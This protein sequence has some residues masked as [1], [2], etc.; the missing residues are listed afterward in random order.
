MDE[1]IGIREFFAVTKT[2]LYRISVNWKDEKGEPEIEKIALKGESS[3][4]IGG[5]ITGGNLVGITKRGIVSYNNSSKNRYRPE[6][7]NILHHG[8]TTSP[9]TALFIKVGEAKIC[10][11]ESKNFQNC[12]P[13][14]RKQ[15]EEVL[16]AIG[17]N[18][19]VFILSVFDAISFE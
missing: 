17:D 18:H 1:K 2:S 16:A 19:P 13:R 3:V 7:V 8:G 10:F 4:P 6:Q 14:W 15:T 9:I 12:D 5:M 11:F